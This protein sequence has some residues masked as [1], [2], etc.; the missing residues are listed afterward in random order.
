ML[1]DII[2]GLLINYTIGQ[3]VQALIYNLQSCLI[4]KI[5]STSNQDGSHIA[6]A[7]INIHS[8][9]I[10]TQCVMYYSYLWNTNTILWLLNLPLEWRK[11]WDWL[12]AAKTICCTTF[13]CYNLAVVVFCSPKSCYNLARSIWWQ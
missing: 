3:T 8:S 1:E 4:I 11:F 10:W 7:Y 2:L 6:Y 13:H 9:F 5:L 12:H